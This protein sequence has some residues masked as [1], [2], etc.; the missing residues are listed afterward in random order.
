MPFVDLVTPQ[1]IDHCVHPCSVSKGALAVA[2][3]VGFIVGRIDDKL[4]Q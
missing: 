2:P 3:L 1:L 4:Q